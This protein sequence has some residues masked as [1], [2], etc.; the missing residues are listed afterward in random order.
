MRYEEGRI[1]RL[2]SEHES[3]FAAELVTLIDDDGE[4]VLVSPLRSDELVRV[5]KAD[6]MNYC[7]SCTTMTISGVFC[8]ETGCRNAHQDDES[9]FDFYAAEFETDYDIFSDEFDEEIS[10]YC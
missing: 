2:H 8:H 9:A 10:A 1:Y 7:D 6:L 3:E 5:D 4:T